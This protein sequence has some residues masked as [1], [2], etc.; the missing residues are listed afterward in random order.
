MADEKK[1]KKKSLPLFSIDGGKVKRRAPHC[2]KC[3]VGFFLAVHDN[4]HTCGA[5]AYTEFLKK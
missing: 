3:G 1:K 2:P 5:C 4:R